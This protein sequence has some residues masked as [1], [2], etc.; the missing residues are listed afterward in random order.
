M[1]QTPTNISLTR[2]HFDFKR[3]GENDEMYY[4]VLAARTLRE[5]LLRRAR[6]L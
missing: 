3:V 4:D 2:P 6:G 1:S 5:G